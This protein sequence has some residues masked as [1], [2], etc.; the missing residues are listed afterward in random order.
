M[1]SRKCNLDF[2]DRECLGEKGRKKAAGRLEKSDE[3]VLGW[4]FQTGKKER[5]GVGVDCPLLF[6]RRP[7]AHSDRREGSSRNTRVWKTVLDSAQNPGGDFC[8]QVACLPFAFS[9]SRRRERRWRRFLESRA[10]PAALLPR[11]PQPQPSP[12]LAISARSAQGAPACL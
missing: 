9:K 3:L 2:W 12:G 7:E 5:D 6:K 8:F 1:P 10:G 4:K 11:P